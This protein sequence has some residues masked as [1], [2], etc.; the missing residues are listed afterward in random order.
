M[1]RYRTLLIGNRRTVLLCK[2]TGMKKWARM[3]VKAAT[4]GTFGPFCSEETNERGFRLLAYAIFSDIV[5]VNTFGHHKASGRWTWHSPNGQLH[6]QTDY[7]LLRKR[8][9][10]GVNIARTRSFPREDVGSDQDLLMMTFHL[11]LKRISE[12]N[13]TR[14]KFDLEKM[15]DPNVL[16]TFHAMIRGKLAMNNKHADIN[17][18]HLQH[19]SDCNSQWD[20]LQ[21][22]S[23]KQGKGKKNCVTVEILYLCDKMW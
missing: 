6:K 5:L 8:F 1:A 2:E 20:P 21:T 12:P 17:D 16:E 22:S 19:S 4:W 14:R 3:V 13:H 11:L 15:K 9:R 18:H 10:S 23:E 7:I